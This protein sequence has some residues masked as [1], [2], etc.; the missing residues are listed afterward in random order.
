MH[1]GVKFYLISARLSLQ[2][3]IKNFFNFSDKTINDSIVSKLFSDDL[4]KAPKVPVH[5]HQSADK[6]NCDNLLNPVLCAN[7]WQM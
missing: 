5:R 3:K 2:K 4:L 6:R 7:K 1:R